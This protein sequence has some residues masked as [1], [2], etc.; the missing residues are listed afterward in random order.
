MK[1]FVLLFG[2]AASLV[3]PLQCW[4]QRLIRPFGW[5]VVEEYWPSGHYPA[6]AAK[7]LGFQ[8]PHNPTLVLDSADGGLSLEM[9]GSIT[10]RASYDFMGAVDNID[11][12]PYDIALGKGYAGEQRLV[13]DGTTS[14]LFAR[15][16]VH[17]GLLGQVEA[18]V[19]GDF[20]G[21]EE[22]SYTPR[23]RSAYL[24]LLGFTVGRAVT[25]FCDL[26]AAPE[27]V[28]FAGPNAYNFN[29]AT[30]L[31][32]E[33]SLLKSHLNLGVGVEMPVVSGSYGDYY[34]AVAQ[35]VPDVPLYVEY[36]WGGRSRS[37][38]RLSAVFRDIYLQ[39]EP[40]KRDIALFGWGVQLSGRLEAHDVVTLYYNG[41]YG[42]GISPYIEDLTSRGLDFM[43]SEGDAHRIQTLP[44]WGLQCSAKVSLRP[45][46]LSV[47]GGYSVVK[48]VRRGDFYR[49]EEY[50]RGTYIF[51]NLFYRVNGDLTLAV[52]YLHGSRKNM[53]SGKGRANRL[54]VMLRYDF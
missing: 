26:Q 42:K 53:D 31:R 12:E 34:S 6:Y 50:R 37:H 15:A 3:I 51:A 11:F 54:S 39:R 9:G 45:R 35:R 17:S 7:K 41:V 28:D 13:M 1:R 46:R 5:G 20:C 49:A 38:I 36:A 44:M 52:E 43:P 16:V 21:G 25:T 33:C 23:L 22:L 18:F 29:F 8:Q 19:S 27:T 30:L 48:M 14:R 40:T 2:V 32:Y 4:A 47:A 10:M 24:S